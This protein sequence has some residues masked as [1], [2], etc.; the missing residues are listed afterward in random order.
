MSLGQD[1][2]PSRN[3]RDDIQLLRARPSPRPGSR[4]L[5]PASGAYNFSGSGSKM[6]DGRSSSPMRARRASKHSVEGY[7]K[8]TVDDAP[9]DIEI[10]LRQK[11][12]H[13]EADKRMQQSSQGVVKLPD[14][15]GGKSITDKIGLTV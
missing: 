3:T 15:L 5:G 9:T 6:A 13:V 14:S 4:D 8:S 10:L 7:P 11:V 2:S 1:K 12:K